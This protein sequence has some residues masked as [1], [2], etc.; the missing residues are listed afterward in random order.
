MLK[1]PEKNSVINEEDEKH[2]WESKIEENKNAIAWEP[3]P[4]EDDA[5]QQISNRNL[6]LKIPPITS[7]DQRQEVSKVIEDKHSN[8]QKKPRLK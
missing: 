3:E 4:E 6:T 1:Q 2:D 5:A 7:N 8:Y